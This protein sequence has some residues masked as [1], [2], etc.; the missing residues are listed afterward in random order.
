MP[1][2]LNVHKGTIEL[3][4]KMVE[5]AEVH[6]SASTIGRYS[7]D[8]SVYE[9]FLDKNPHTKHNFLLGMSRC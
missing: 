8:L 2:L 1:I 9:Q 5:K 7:S 3:T 6:L 4:P